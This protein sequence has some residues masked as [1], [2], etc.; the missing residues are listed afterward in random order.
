MYLDIIS[1]NY[2]SD[3]RVELTF[4]NG[5]S[6]VVDFMKFIAKGGVFSRLS[7]LA[8]FREFQVNEE[9]G[10]ITWGGEIDV[11]PEILYSEATGEPLPHWMRPEGEMRETA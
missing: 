5:R 4:E 2:V 10:I 9:L 8:F 3:F 6:G 11:A 7:D 1:A